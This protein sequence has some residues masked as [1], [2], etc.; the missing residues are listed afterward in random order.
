[1]CKRSK[2]IIE[3]KKNPLGQE[4]FEYHLENTHSVWKY[5][6][7]RLY[8]D[9]KEKND[10]TGIEDIIYNKISESKLDW[11]PSSEV[12]EAE[13]I[14]T[15]IEEQTVLLN[16]LKTGM[17]EQTKKNE[18]LDKLKTMVEELTKNVDSKMEVL[19]K[20]VEAILQPQQEAGAPNAPV[21]NPA[22]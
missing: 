7:Y 9:K 15:Y 8:L 17:E 13:V 12:G 1:M 10:Y 6:N 19:T 11:I 20:K 16:N 4:E 21:P 22:A 3:S 5:L 2:E 14:P 18:V